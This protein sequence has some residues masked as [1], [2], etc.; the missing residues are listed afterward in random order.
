MKFKKASELNKLMKLVGGPFDGR[1]IQTCEHREEHRE[2]MSVDG[3]E[4]FSLYRKTEEVD[5]SGFLI[6]QFE[7][8]KRA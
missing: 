8:Y 4:H 5:A 1:K 3:D 2:F 7:G 6:Y